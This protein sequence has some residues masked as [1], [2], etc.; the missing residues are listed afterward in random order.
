MDIHPQFLDRHKT[1][2]L[3][4]LARHSDLPFQGV[5][6]SALDIGQNKERKPLPNQTI[7]RTAYKEAAA[8]FDVRLPTPHYT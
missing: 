4:R 8:D 7:Q 5:A 3:E 2:I 1:L 6:G